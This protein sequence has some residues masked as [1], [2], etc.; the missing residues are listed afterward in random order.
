[1][2]NKATL[3]YAQEVR[4]ALPGVEVDTSPVL[5]DTIDRLRAIKDAAEI[6]AMRRAQAITDACFSYILPKIRPGVREIDLALDMEMFM[7][8]HGAGK[9]AFPIIF[10]AGSKT[11]LPHGEPGENRIQTGD[12]VTMD[13]GANVDGYCTDMTRT[14]AVGHVTDE[15]KR[16]YNTVLQAQLSGC[17][18]A[19]A[20]QRGC[21]VDRVARD[22]IAAMG[23]GAY[24]GHGLGHA[25]GIEI[26]EEPRYSSSCEEIIRAGMMMTIEP[27]IYLPGKFGVRI[28]DT[29]LIGEEGCEILGSSDKNLLIL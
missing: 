22:F 20:G 24:F 25:V 14:V 8:S 10:V 18:Y 21:E 23:Y 1:M 27:G 17:S 5:S 29:V 11:S 28:E 4:D 16:V 19:K 6:A 12:F 2:E 3:A 7:R 9:L 26:H 15:Q 13:F